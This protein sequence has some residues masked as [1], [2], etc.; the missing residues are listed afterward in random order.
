MLICVRTSLNINDQLMRQAKLFAVGSGVTLTEVVESALRDK[1][2]SV[3]SAPPSTQIVLPVSRVSGG[4]RPEFAGMLPSHILAE[5][6]ES[7]VRF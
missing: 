2:Q 7:D 3:M 6:E 1:L 4:L 5:L